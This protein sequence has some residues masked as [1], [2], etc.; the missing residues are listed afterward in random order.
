MF[1]YMYKV[2][3]WFFS[4]RWIYK[5]DLFMFTKKKNILKILKAKYCETSSMAMLFIFLL[6]SIW[7]IVLLKASNRP[8]MYISV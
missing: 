7:I 1:I 4:L 6:D 8:N 3:F 5:N 2:T